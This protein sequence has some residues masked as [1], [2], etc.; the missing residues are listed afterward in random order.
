MIPVSNNPYMVEAVRYATNIDYS[1]RTNH[2][3]Q[4]DGNTHSNKLS[5][6]TKNSLVA[7]KTNASSYNFKYLY[8]VPLSKLNVT[9]QIFNE[10]EKPLPS[11]DKS[12]NN[13]NPNSLNFMNA[14]SAE[15]IAYGYYIV[16]SKISSNPKNGSSTKNINPVKKKLEKTYNAAANSM[17]GSLVNIVY[18]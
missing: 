10:K 7:D 3:A 5:Q 4:T 13:Y 9:G 16:D 18:Y 6:D 14:G 12:S 11:G 17:P 15:N 2:Y 1:Q 8:N